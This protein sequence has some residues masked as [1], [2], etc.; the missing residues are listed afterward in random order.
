MSIADVMCLISWF[1]FILSLLKQPKDKKRGNDGIKDSYF[2]M[3]PEKGD[4]S[5]GTFFDIPSI[6]TSSI[7]PAYKKLTSRVDASSFQNHRCKIAFNHCRYNQQGDHHQD[8]GLGQM[9]EHGEN[10]F[11]FCFP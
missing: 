2:Y 9:I 4:S 10:F 1:V 3:S 11:L 6:S 7:S 8:K 5:Q